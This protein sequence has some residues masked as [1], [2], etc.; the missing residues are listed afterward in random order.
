MVF[1]SFLP[2]NSTQF[3]LDLE[4]ATAQWLDTELLSSIWNADTCPIQ[5]LPWLAWALSVDIWDANWLDAVKRD[6]VKQSIAIHKKKGTLWAIKRLL[7]IVGVPECSIVEWFEQVPVAP[8][9]TFNLQI[10]SN[11]GFDPYILD[12]AQWKRIQRIIDSVKPERSVF[13]FEI[14]TNF[15]NNQQF[16]DELE[17]TAPF[18][19][20]ATTKSGYVIKN[21]VVKS[22]PFALDFQKNVAV[23][24]TFNFSQ[25]RKTTAKVR[26][27]P[28]QVNFLDGEAFELLEGRSFEF[29]YPDYSVLFKFLDGGTFKFLNNQTFEMLN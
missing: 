24:N 6:V 17:G 14:L 8:S 15:G 4:N 21:A 12:K 11:P 9:H 18:L 3:E 5:F 22:E 1:P 2:P 20:S 23:G 28:E 26:V 27:T 25:Y 16:G 29:L 10:V 19:A 13:F 7:T